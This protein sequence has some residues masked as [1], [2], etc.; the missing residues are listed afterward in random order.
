LSIRENRRRAEQSLDRYLLA[1]ALFLLAVVAIAPDK[2]MNTICFGSRW[3]PVAAVLLI[4]ALPAPS[5]GRLPAPAVAFLLVTVFF[6]AAGVAW[7]RYDAR[8]LS[9][10]E[11]SLRAIAPSSR[12][13]GLDLVKE[14]H[15]IEGRPFMQLAAYAQVLKGGELNFSFAE[16][17]SG[18]VA[19]KRPRQVPWTHGLEWQAE[20][21]KRSDLGYF[22]FVLVNADGRN[23][24]LLSSFAELLPVT[25]SGR[26]RT[27]RVLR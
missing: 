16:H 22:D 19:Y 10:F 26:W 20:R 21:F 8:E 9:G 25:P 7:W 1:A 14:S 11:S 15:Y 24:D 3:F 13:L 27:Y 4:L 2:Y 17:Y 23:H 5:F 12:V 18:L 6:L